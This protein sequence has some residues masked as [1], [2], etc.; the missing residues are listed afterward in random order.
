LESIISCGGQIELPDGF[1]KG[2]YKAVR[3]A[4][5]LCIADEV[6][7]G[8]GRVGSAF[9]GFEL[10]GVVPDIVTIGKPFGNGHPVAA[11]VCT[12][13]V[14]EKFANGMEYFNTFGGNPVSCAIAKSVL[15]VIE[16]EELQ[17]N[18]LIVG[19]AFKNGLQ[20][21]S[22]HHPIVGSI[23]GKGLFLGIELV[24]QELNPL[25]S[26]ASYLVNRMKQNGVLMSTDGPD[27]NVIKIKPPLTFSLANVE[28]VLYHLNSILNEDYMKIS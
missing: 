14:A 13:E 3:A 21:L 7:T 25:A 10:H 24:D 17:K 2:V 6:Q 8:L 27:H 4:G 11:V 23:R 22:Q 5:G 15:E 1:L 26:Q 16:E 9:W 20:E 12:E 19:T 28:E 18:A